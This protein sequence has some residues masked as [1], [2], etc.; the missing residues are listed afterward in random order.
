MFCLAPEAIKAQ[1]RCE[2]YDRVDSTN[3]LAAA[4]A[5]HGDCG[6]L[7]IVADEQ[8]AGRGRRGRTWSSPSGNLY[9]TLLLVDE[10]KSAVAATL[11]FV[12]GVSLVETLYS[13]LEHDTL[14][15]FPLKLK[16]PNDVLAGGAKLTGI[17]LEF[18]SLSDQRNALAIGIGVNVAH[19]PEDTPYPTTNL[20]KMGAGVTSIEIFSAL[21]ACW[22]ANYELWNRGEGL[23]KIRDKWLSFAANLGKTVSIIVDGETVSGQFETI[24]EN[25]HFILATANGK[26]IAISAGEVH[27]GTIASVHR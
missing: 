7:W 2:S 5:H 15:E 23:A 3:S 9:A 1:Y 22:T 21:S 10:F 16:W 20:R 13:I 24:D 14:V 12:A 18:L 4:F 25:C 6:K 8:T 11:G 27:F 26:K 19:S 17:L